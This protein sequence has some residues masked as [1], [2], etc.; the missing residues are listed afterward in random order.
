MGGDVDSLALG[1]VGQLYDGCDALAPRPLRPDVGGRPAEL[2]AP[3]EADAMRADDCAKVH[4]VLVTR[5]GS[6]VEAGVVEAE[7]P[8]LV[9]RHDLSDAE[10]VVVQPSL[11]FSRLVI[12]PVGKGF[13]G[14]GVDVHDGGPLDEQRAAFGS[15]VAETK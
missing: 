8:A 1:G 5:Q 15:V 7:V 12:R 4:L 11:G 10:A 2:L 13:D 14:D 6:P 3:S 9:E